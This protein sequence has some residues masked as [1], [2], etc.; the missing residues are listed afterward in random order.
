MC[1]KSGKQIQSSVPLSLLSYKAICE[2]A[3]SSSSAQGTRGVLR[4]QSLSPELCGLGQVP[5]FSLP[6]FLPLKK[7]NRQESLFQVPDYPAGAAPAEPV[8]P[9]VLFHFLQSSFH[10]P[11]WSP[12]KVGWLWGVCRAQLD[13][14][15]RVSRGKC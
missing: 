2:R 5:F 9:A 10:L 3:A 6:R 15:G 12:R 8:V 14:A 7:E 1:D 4:A 11:L 13:T